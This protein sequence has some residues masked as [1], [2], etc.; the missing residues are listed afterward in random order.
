MLDFPSVGLQFPSDNLVGVVVDYH[1]RYP[2]F[3]SRIFIPTLSVERDPLN[4]IWGQLISRLI[5]EV[6]K[7][8]WKKTQIKIEG[9]AML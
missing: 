2:W 5:L 9:I 3:D 8:G 4:L 6:A 1:K 7:S